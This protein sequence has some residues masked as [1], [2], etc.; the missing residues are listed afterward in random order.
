MD[1]DTTTS[2]ATTETG[3]A[4]AQANTASG[5]APTIANITIASMNAGD[6][7]GWLHAATL[8]TTTG[9]VGYMRRY[10]ESRLA[11]LQPQKPLDPGQSVTW[12]SDPS[13][14]GEVIGYDESGAVIVRTLDGGVLKAVR[15]VEIV[16]VVRAKAPSMSARKERVPNKRERVKSPKKAGKRG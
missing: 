4:Q 5:P 3:Q 9:D 1:D 2:T 10:H 11:A 6:F 13:Q 14:K 8:A 16:P 7:V 15:A 12:K